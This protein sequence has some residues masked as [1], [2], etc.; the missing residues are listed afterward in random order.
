MENSKIVDKSVALRAVKNAV[1]DYLEIRE[2]QENSTFIPWYDLPLSE[3]DMYYDRGGRLSN[4]ESFYKEVKS[5]ELSDELKNDKEFIS[6]VKELISSMGC[7]NVSYIMYNVLGIDDT[8]K[9]I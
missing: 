1:I 5:I 8:Q 3:I 2:E 9:K 7:D 4:E 6:E